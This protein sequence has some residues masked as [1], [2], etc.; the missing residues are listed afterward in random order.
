MALIRRRKK[1]RTPQELD[2]LTILQLRGRRA[3]LTRPRHV[4]H[5]LYF[6]G[7]AAARA[8]VE[9]VERAGY[10]ATVLEPKDDDSD[11]ALHAEDTRVVDDTT[12]PA[13]RVLFERIAERHGGT[14]DGW[15][16]AAEP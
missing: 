2:T 13:F 1:P 15:E 6:P 9:D 7:E 11:W 10:D 5:V 3:D 12:V 8:A 4:L 14:Y 16:A